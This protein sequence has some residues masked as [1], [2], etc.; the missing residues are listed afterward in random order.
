M[1]VS[2]KFHN[3][4]A[5]IKLFLIFLLIVGNT[6][7][8]IIEVV[9]FNPDFAF[10]PR[11]S[12]FKD[13]FIRIPRNDTGSLSSFTYCFRIKIATTITQCLFEQDD[14]GLGFK[15]YT[16]YYGF[17]TIHGAWI[18]FEYNARL[19]PIKWYHVCMSYDSGHILLVMNDQTLMDEESYDLKQLKDT[20]LIL[21]DRLTLGFCNGGDI[22]PLTS[23]TRGLLTD[24][25]MWST[26]FSETALLRFT[27][28]CLPLSNDPNVINWNSLKSAIEGENVDIVNFGTNDV[29]DKKYPQD[30][31]KSILLI[32]LE[33]PYKSAKL[34]CETLGGNFPMLRNAQDIHLWNET[35]RLETIKRYDT[36]KNGNITVGTCK[37]Q[38]W[39]PIRQNGMKND[40]SLESRGGGGY[41][42]SEDTSH[43]TQ[44]APYLPWAF[45]QPNGLEY[46]Q[47]VA[48]SL[49]TG[50]I[51]DH[52]CRAIERCSLC[53][54]YG[55]IKFHIRGLPKTS[56]IDTDY[57][58][59]PRLQKENG[60]AFLGYRQY[61]IRWIYKNNSWE[62]LDRSNLEHVIGHFQN[63]QSKYPIGSGYW[64][65]SSDNFESDLI[66][67]KLSKVRF[68]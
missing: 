27:R 45:S 48:I 21:N 55:A 5:I 65:I 10:D 13:N 52:D 42:W 15:F 63:S 33:K 53:E 51:L 28:E 18:M 20:R 37:N 39:V 41:L 1:F 14:L 24:F 38:F 34:L 11:E 46:Q 3:A 61:L 62:I 16:E 35:I 60:M 2:E 43:R 8:K 56:P 25:N 47:C 12:S 66:R 49:A 59:E 19:D 7:A 9:R 22:D 36:K 57:I 4:F 68:K 40:S 26:S 6:S 31:D 50:K 32:P 30:A 54:F 29:C 58:F 67:L 23:I 44:I 64:K 17:L